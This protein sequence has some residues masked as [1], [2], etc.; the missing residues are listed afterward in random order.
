MTGLLAGVMAAAAF[1]AWTNPPGEVRLRAG[2]GRSRR[3]R[4]SHR[5]LFVPMTVG[6]ALVLVVLVAPGVL[7]WAVIVCAVGGTLG[8]VARQHRRDTRA[9]RNSAQ[10]ARACEVIA[11][12]LQIG[13]TPGQALTIAAEECEVLVMCVSAQQIGADVTEALTT[14]AAEPGCAG[15]AGLARTW[16][17]CERTGSRLSPAAQL[18]AQAVAAEGQLQSEITAELAVPRATGKLLAMLPVVGIA[19]GFVAGGDPV[20]FLTSTLPGRVCLAAAVLLACA[21]LLWTEFIASR[22]GRQS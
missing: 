21:G 14:A 9:A 16:R 11:A 17:L 18:V 3:G 4:G 19:M 7:A 20:S 15:L 12:Q 6:M 10:V 1:L 13:R 5:I 2:F 8:W 22:A